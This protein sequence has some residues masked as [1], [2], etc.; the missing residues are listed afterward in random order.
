M[1]TM[2]IVS[3]KKPLLDGLEL[4]FYISQNQKTNIDIK[5]VANECSICFFKNP[6]RCRFMTPATVFEI[7]HAFK[8]RT[9]QQIYN[10]L[11]PLSVDSR[12]L[13]IS[14]FVLFSIL[15][16]DEASA[17]TYFQCSVLHFETS[18]R[19]HLAFRVF[20]VS[21]HKGSHISELVA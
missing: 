12:P 14:F 10:V 20:R 19:Y 18:P 8:E 13:L 4:K 7:R 5:D 17:D 9:T 1:T 2:K 6:I 16:N 3:P 15:R 11:E 21:N